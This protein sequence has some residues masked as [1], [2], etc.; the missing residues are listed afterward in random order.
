VRVGHAI[1]ANDRARVHDAARAAYRT[2]VGFMCVTA[3][4]FLTVP[5]WLAT[6]FTRPESVG[7]TDVIALAAT[8]IPIA[9]VFQIFDGAQAVGAGVLR[10]MGDTRVPLI[11]MLAGYWLL[12][13]PVS[14]FLAF[15]TPLGAQGLWWGFVVSLGT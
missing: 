14:A 2:G 4:V 3:I 5:R 11:A 6:Q 8:L 1:G 9:G 13:V 10:G 7:A 12:G 15:R